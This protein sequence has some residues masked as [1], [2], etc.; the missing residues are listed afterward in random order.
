MVDGDVADVF[1]IEAVSFLGMFEPA[2]A[3]KFDDPVVVGADPEGVALDDEAVDELVFEFF[4]KIGVVGPLSVLEFVESLGGADP[5]VA[6]VVGGDGKNIVA[7]QPRIF[8]G[9][10]GPLLR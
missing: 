9:I 7:Y 5:E 8:L 10:V 1:H 2:V 3:V 4:V 6:A